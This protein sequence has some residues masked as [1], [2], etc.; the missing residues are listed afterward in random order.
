MGLSHSRP[1]LVFAVLA[2]C[3]AIAAHAQDA[4]VRTVDNPYQ[5]EFD[6]TL[7]EILA[8]NVEVE[9]VRWT[10]MRVAPRGSGQVDPGDDEV[11]IEL[12]IALDNRG[13]D[14]ARVQ[15]VVLLEDGA[16]QPLDRL[17]LEPIRV[18]DG[19]NENAAERF[20]VSGASLLAVEKVYL[21]L[22][23]ER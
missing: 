17:S 1:F 16:G 21:F 22:E 7:G 3:T 9:G 8:P 5:E 12:T 11:D 20:K 2:M 15:V 10:S 13:T 6:Y 14:D 23:L 4:D 18:R 19:R